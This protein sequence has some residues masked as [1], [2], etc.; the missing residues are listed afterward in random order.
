MRDEAAGA[1]SCQSMTI[2]TDFTPKLAISSNADARVAGSARSTGA[3]NVI[4]WVCEA[5][6]TPGR[7]TAST[8]QSATDRAAIRDMAG[9][10]GGRDYNRSVAAKVAAASARRVTRSTVATRFGTITVAA[11]PDDIV[12]SH[13]AA[14]RNE[15]PPLLVLEPLRA[16]LDEHGLGSGDLAA[17]P[18]G[19]GHSNVT[20]VVRRGGRERV[21]RR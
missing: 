6:A 11:A 12:V 2:R 10:V 8:A 16:F 20:Y 14:A 4:D 15:R 9:C 1:T 5:A 17:E 7:A 13:A 19:E 21:V 18:V 3:S